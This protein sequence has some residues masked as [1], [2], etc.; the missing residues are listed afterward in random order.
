MPTA[1]RSRAAGSGLVA[2]GLAAGWLGAA[3]AGPQT[4]WHVPSGRESRFQE[5]LRVCRMLTDEPGGVPHDS[6][7]EACMERRGFRRQNVFERLLDR[8]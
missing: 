4:P 1:P 2:A 7:F 6:R 5:T 3:C 8:D